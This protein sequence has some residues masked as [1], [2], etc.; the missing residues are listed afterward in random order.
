MRASDTRLRLQRFGRKGLPFYRIVAAHKAAPRDGKFH[1]ILG[2]FN[3]LPDRYGAT[4]V[5]FNVERVKYWLV[6]GATASE[7]VLHLLG[8]AELIPPP[9]RRRDPL[10]EEFLPKTPPRWDQLGLSAASS[11]TRATSS[12][13]QAVTSPV[14]ED[15]SSELASDS[16]SV[17]SETSGEESVSSSE[18][19]SDTVK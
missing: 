4:H 13:T 6:Q 16:E 17:S 5:T 7:R 10:L 8:R 11:M 1:E 2:T 9:P 18:S 12:V 3:P 15:P 14:V 19:S